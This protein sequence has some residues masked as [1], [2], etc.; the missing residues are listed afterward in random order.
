[1]ERKR[2]CQFGKNIVMAIVA[3]VGIGVSTA[4][5]TPPGYVDATTFGGG[6]NATD[7][8]ATLQAAINSGQDIYVPKM[9]SDWIITPVFLT[10]SNQKILFQDGVVV[11]AKAGAFMGTNDSLFK[12][13]NVS[14]VEMIG[15]GATLQMRKSDYTQPPYPAG[16]W[17]MGVSI[18]GGSGVTVKG[19]TIQNT[20]GDGIYLGTG[21]SNTSATNVL[22]KDVVLKNNDRQGISIVN[23]DGVT[24][25]NAVSL[26]TSGTAPSAGIDI[27]PDSTTNV[28]K[29]I[30]IKNSIFASNAGHGI[31]FDFNLG[32]PTAATNLSIENVTIFGNSVDGI[33]LRET[34]PGL[35]IKDSLI[36]SNTRYGAYAWATT[37]GTT[38]NYLDYTA[39]LSNGSGALHW[40]NKMQFGPGGVSGLSGPLFYSTD[41]N[42]PY[43]LYLDPNV[44]NSIAL[45]AS[46]GSFIGARPVYTTPVPEPAGMALILLGGGM[47]LTK[48]R[49]DGRNS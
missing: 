21:V 11:T 37:P 19:F 8:T 15:Y 16:E 34:L 40:N 3:A 22:I 38:V 14:N 49:G 48:R 32:T 5:A 36:V 42:S 33:N 41:P 10:K 26:S 9:S 35:T 23:A 20:G 30:A 4:A 24:I 47:I 43:F 1:M 39:I 46:D 12:A 13:T 7:S 25:D 28:I 31:Q 44:A 45:G 27:E 6:F 17:R 29:N 2:V 18:L